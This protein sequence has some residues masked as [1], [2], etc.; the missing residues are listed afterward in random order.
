MSHKKRKDRSYIE[1][2]ASVVASETES[3]LAE[4]DSKRIKAQKFRNFFK[5]TSYVD[6]FDPIQFCK[7]MGLSVEDLE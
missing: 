6:H 2:N 5:A 1:L 7:Q 4:E 3:K